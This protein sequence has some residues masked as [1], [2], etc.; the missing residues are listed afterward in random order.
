MDVGFC[1]STVLPAGDARRGGGGGMS[2]SEETVGRAFEVVAY[3]A[4]LD[5]LCN[6][7]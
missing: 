1:P 7:E 4:V 3:H 2:T 5:G 6:P